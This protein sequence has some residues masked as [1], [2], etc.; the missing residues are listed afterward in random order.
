MP[1]KRF[2]IIYAV[3]LPIFFGIDLIWLGVVAST[4]YPRHLGHLLSGQVHWVPAILFYLVFIAGI[5]FL[6]VKPAAEARK[7][8]RALVNGAVLGFV[9]YATYDLTNQATMRD[10]PLVVTVIDLV[11]GT[12]LTGSVA[13]V[14]YLISRQVG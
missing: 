5:V 4:F 13:G 3:T 11:W 7:A 1:L 10:W 9:A 12:V 14:S 8:G 6:A 2:L